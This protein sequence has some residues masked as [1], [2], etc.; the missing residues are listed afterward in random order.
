MQK[1]LLITL[2]LLIDACN[3]NMPNSA[4]ARVPRLE[5]FK[6]DSK[7]PHVC[8]LGINPGVTSSEDAL[9]ILMASNEIDHASFFKRSESRI[10]TEW[11]T[12][13][14][15]LYSADVWVNFEAGLVQSI[16]FGTMAPFRMKDL[17]SLLGE[18]DEILIRLD[19]T[20]D[21]GDIVTYA[22]YSSTIRTTIY[23]YPGSR[24]GPNSEDFIDSLVLNSDLVFPIGFKKVQPQQWRGYGHLRDYLPG[25]ELPSGPYG[26]AHP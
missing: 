4:Q 21:G 11:K 23:V 18:P 1:Y 22:T 8:W 12:D 7:C 26:P 19:H 25:Q 24:D 6:V 16:N 15:N 9:A 10:Q 5:A 13:K 20:T 17:I 2:L 14:S 3:T